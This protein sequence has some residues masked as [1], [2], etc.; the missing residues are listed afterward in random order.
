MQR[1]A[2]L[3]SQMMVI[4]ILLVVSTLIYFLES[5]AQPEIFGSIPA[6]MW[7]GIATLTTVG[8]G[9]VVPITELGKGIAVLIM[10]LG[11][12]IIAVPTGIVSAEFAKNDKEQLENQDEILSKEDEILNKLNALASK[13]DKLEENKK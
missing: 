13:I 10:M 11:Y 9:D 4:S 7:W 12:A 3:G 8:Y 5:E 2:L 6:A 1:N